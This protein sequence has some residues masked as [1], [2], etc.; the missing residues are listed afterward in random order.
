MLALAGRTGPAGVVPISDYR[1]EQLLTTVGVAA[2]RRHITTVLGPLVGQPDWEELRATVISWT[3][4]GFQLTG[5]AQR[6]HIHRNTLIYRL[7]KIQ[8]ITGRDMRDHRYAL[9]AHLACLLYGQV[10]DR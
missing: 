8:R 3:E 6:L 5:A 4:Q 10:A 7:Q 2:R 9:A 1:V